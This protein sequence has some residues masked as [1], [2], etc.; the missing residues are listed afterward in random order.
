MFYVLMQVFVDYSIC[1][2][3]SSVIFNQREIA[4]DFA[5]ISPRIKIS[6]R[7][8]FAERAS[9]KLR[10]THWNLDL[11]G[12]EHLRCSYSTE[13]LIPCKLE[14]LQYNK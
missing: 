12:W 9:S 5:S 11:F 7:R 6:L 14:T 10:R 4:A 1:E 2:N 8:D 13:A 3:T